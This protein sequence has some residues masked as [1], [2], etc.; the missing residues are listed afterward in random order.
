M[1]YTHKL[2]GLPELSSK[3]EGSRIL[4]L[5]GGDGGLLKELLDHFTSIDKKGP[6]YIHM[7]DIDPVVM[8]ACS[9]FMPKVCGEYI[10]KREGPNYKIVEG[11]AFE[12]MEKLLS[13]REERFD[14]IFG[15]LTDTPIQIDD[16][17]DKCDANSNPDNVTWTFI[18]EILASSI[19]LLKPGGRYM[20]HCQGK[21][22]VSA[23]NNYERMAAKMGM[24]ILRRESFVPSFME[25][26]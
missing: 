6:T 9:K 13:N 14:F 23:I 21:S 16:S 5:G 4:I 22:A 12:E 11:D 10:S 25:V 19:R 18:K 7:V 17:R 26:W 24:D 15:D 8:D 2:M 1:G 20:T 3:Y